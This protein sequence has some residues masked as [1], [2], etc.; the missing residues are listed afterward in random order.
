VEIGFSENYRA[1]FAQARDDR[2]ILFG[3]V[4]GTHSRGRTR[5]LAGDIDEILDRN[6]HAMQWTAVD[7][8]ATF[9]VERTRCGARALG[10]DSD[11]RVCPLAVLGDG[12]KAQLDLLS[13]S[14]H[15]K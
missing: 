1:C 13:S 5:G 9:F 6:G 10:V 7:S 3:N 2:G 15:R 14:G 4:S 12:G 8:A 11:E